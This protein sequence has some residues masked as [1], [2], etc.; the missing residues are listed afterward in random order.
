MSSRS[1]K[2]LGIN[3]F[4]L[5]RTLHRD[6]GYFCVGL[7]IVFAVSGIAVNHIRDWNPNYSVSQTQQQLT[8]QPWQQLS[9]SEL[10]QQM[11]Q[12][13]DTQLPKKTSYWS[14]ANEF[15]LFLQN[16]SNLTLDTEH[17]VLHAELIKPRHV[18]Q[19]FNKLHL[20]EG[21]SAWVIFSD[22]YAAML[23]F[24][25]LSALFMVKGKYSPWRKR[26]V[27]VIAGIVLPAAFV[28]V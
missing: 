7:T 26:S 10:E 14:S 20:N 13:A 9:D 16:G 6:I 2:W 27:L 11:L 1:S 12:A 15:K 24:L 28:F 21:H 8:P 25:A 22:L 17:S 4:K 19:A 18:L 3:W 23:L 5:N